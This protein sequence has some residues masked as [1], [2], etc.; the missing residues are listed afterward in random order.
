MAVRI[1]GVLNATPDSFSDG[2]SFADVDEAVKAGRALAAQGADII[3]VGGE[4]T[5]PGAAPVPGDEEAA[6]VLPV[7]EALRDLTVSIDTRHAA[8]AA[9]ALD[10]GAEIVND[11]SA[12]ADPEMFAVAADHAAGLVLMHMQG[13]PRTMQTEPH[14]DDVVAEVEGYL[15]ARATAAE[16][17]GV[18]KERI[19]IDPGIG[20]GK[21]LEHN[22][23]LLR[24]T[25]R[26]AAH[27]YPVL[28]G[29]SRK[30]F[31]GALT[32][33][34]VQNRGDATTAAVALCVY[35]GASVVRVHDAAAARDAVAVAEGW[36]GFYSR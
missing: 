9:S 28:V 14:Y 24:A 34:E 10:A 4:S 17:A 2:G 23:A 36:S 8:V 32:G 7:I 15:L 31:L 25:P 12:G 19:W 18:A 35:A 21:S 30:R 20:F 11:V 3:D 1:M 33:R 16:Q 6:R 27:G 22:L 26:L 13:D 29:V 5:R